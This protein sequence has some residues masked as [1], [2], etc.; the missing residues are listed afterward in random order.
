MRKSLITA[1]CI[2]ESLLAIL[3]GNSYDVAKIDKYPTPY[4]VRRVFH[5]LPYKIQQDAEK[6]LDNTLVEIAFWLM[7]EGELPHGVTINGN[8]KGGEFEYSHPDRKKPIK[9]E[10]LVDHYNRI[11]LLSS[12]VVPNEKETD[13]DVPSN[14]LFFYW[15][16][17]NIPFDNWV[18]EMKNS[19][20]ASEKEASERAD[21]IIGLIRGHGLKNPYIYIKPLTDRSDIREARYTVN[22]EGDKS[23]FRIYLYPAKGHGLVILTGNRK[24]NDAQQRRFLNKLETWVSKIKRNFEDYTILR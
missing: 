18:D 23:M 20:V 11:V 16:G 6:S 19:V 8:K 5:S 7:E 4:D 24:L 22:L 13:D 9:V 10:F 1:K 21:D 3:E 17:Q 15:T 14:H 12:L 2:I